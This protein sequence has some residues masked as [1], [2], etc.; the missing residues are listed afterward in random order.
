MHAHD[1]NTEN[2]VGGRI[3]RAPAEVLNII[4]VLYAASAASGPAPGFRS[5]Y[6]LFHLHAPNNFFTF[7]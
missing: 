2:C 6:C 3:L 7:I 4:A 5:L 1:Y